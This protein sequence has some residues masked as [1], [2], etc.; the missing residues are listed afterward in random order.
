M[1]EAEEK[2]DRVRCEAY[3]EI[4]RLTGIYSAR[5]CYLMEKYN[6]GEL[7]EADVKAWAEGKEF[8]IVGEYGDSEQVV[9]KA[10]VKEVAHEAVKK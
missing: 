2:I 3:S 10:V 7:S 4:D 1:R 5:L 8:R 9:W 6:G